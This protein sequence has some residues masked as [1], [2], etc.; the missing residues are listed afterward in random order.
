MVLSHRLLRDKKMITYDPRALLR[1]IAPVS[2]IK[3]LLSSR[4]SLKKAALNFV[5]SV[6]FIDKKEVTR[7]ALN[8]VNSYK[9]R[10]ADETGDDKS[11]L[12]QDLLDDPAL[13]IQRVQNEVI[14]QIS[15]E[16]KN[17]YDGEQYEWLPSDAFD[18]RPEHQLL[19]GQVFT[20]GQGEMP[21]DAYGCQCGMNILVKGSELKLG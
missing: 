4:L 13:L 16:I 5:D 12:R 20:I 1:K 18:P 17:N 10:V 19:Y 6:D 2:K 21:G 11:Q 8:V 7:V 9:K 15:G 3:R 14:T